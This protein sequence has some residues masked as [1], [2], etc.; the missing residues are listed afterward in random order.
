MPDLPCDPLPLTGDPDALAEPEE[1]LLIE[2]ELEDAAPDE[3]LSLLVPLVLLPDE[4][5]VLDSPEED[6]SR[7][8]P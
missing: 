8:G 2:G 1:P 7:Q 4:L 3:A 5:G 6:D